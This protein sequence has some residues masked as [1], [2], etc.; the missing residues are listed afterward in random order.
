[1]TFSEAR[2]LDLTPVHNGDE[3]AAFADIGF[4]TKTRTASRVVI[5]LGE[6]TPNSRLD[7]AVGDRLGFDFG[8]SA[9]GD[10]PLP[11]IGES[12]DEG[13]VTIENVSQSA[14]QYLGDPSEG[15][16]I[17]VTVVDEKVTQRFFRNPG[18]SRIA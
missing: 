12:S 11:G 5:V 14:P 2:T 3:L 8:R 17:L 16:Q 1:M 18:S 10:P 4:G 13:W 15:E 6:R 7:G 9:D